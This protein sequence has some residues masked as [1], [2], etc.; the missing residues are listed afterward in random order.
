[1]KTPP[2]QYSDSEAHELVEEFIAQYSKAGEPV[3]VR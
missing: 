2:V 3:K 1:M